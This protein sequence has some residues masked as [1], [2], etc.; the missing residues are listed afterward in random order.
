MSCNIVSLFLYKINIK[1]C[2]IIS[3]ILF[4]IKFNINKVRYDVAL[5]FFYIKKKNFISIINK[6]KFELYITQI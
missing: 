4:Y 2:N 5:H 3:Q 1:K 6:N